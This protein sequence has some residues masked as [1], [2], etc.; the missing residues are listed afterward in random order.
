[1]T[2]QEALRE[3][4]PA[5]ETCVQ[6]AQRRWD[7]IAKPL[8]S[9]GLLEQAVCRIAGITGTAD[10]TIEKRC[11]AVM[12]ADNGVVC[13]GV[14]QSDCEITAIVTENFAK[15]RTSACAM[16]RHAH[17]DVIPVDIGVYRDID[18]PGVLRRKIMY[19]TNDMTLCSAMAREQA[20]RAIE[21]GIDLAGCL[22]KQGYRLI[23]TGEMGIG[24]TTTSSAMISVLLQQPV[25]EVTGHG[26]G[27]SSD[28]LNRKV[29][30]IKKAIEVNRPDPEDPLDVLS[31]VGGLDIA[32]I[33]GLF[34][35]GAV[36]K[37]PVMIDG[38]ISSVAALVAQR[39]APLSAD[40]MLASHVSKEP[41][42]ALLLSA[43]RQK[44]LI[45][46]EMCLGEGTG[47]IAAMGL[48]DMALCVY[49]EMCTFSQT[50]IEQYKPLE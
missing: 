5:D 19:G 24:N 12:C 40:Y 23:A 20:I 1:M 46:C 22:K 9:L 38:V 10:V 14:A 11:V 43:L 2:L 8:N 32:G 44:P 3:I 6:E 48:L 35:G 26:A 47:A 7:S 17:A 28:G 41:A 21:V 36:H 13:R 25:E 37:V 16:A 45:S 18:T 33:A 29:C 15:G 31:K 42:G 34:L 27:L 4:S 30:A 50:S 39:L 49:R